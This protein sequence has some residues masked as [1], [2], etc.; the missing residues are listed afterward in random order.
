MLAIDDNYDVLS[1]GPDILGQIGWALSLVHNR[2]WADR[3]DA[4]AY[5]AKLMIGL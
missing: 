5:Y 2:Q 4:E 1:F 3:R